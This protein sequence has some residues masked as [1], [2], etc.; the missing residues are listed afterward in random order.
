MNVDLDRDEIYMLAKVGLNALHQGIPGPDGLTLHYAI[1]K[2]DAALRIKTVEARRRL[3]DD[4]ATMPCPCYSCRSIIAYA[5]VGPGG[6]YHFRA[7]EGAVV[8]SEG[9]GHWVFECI[10]KHRTK[11]S[12]PGWAP[13]P[14]SLKE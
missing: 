10:E 9:D 5:A 12:A 1:K 14:K 13:P 8:I 11:M 7:A 2:L 6:T 3:L 4:E